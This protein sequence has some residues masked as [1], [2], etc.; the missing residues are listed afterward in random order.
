MSLCLP[1]RNTIEI[2]NVQVKHKFVRFKPMRACSGSRGKAPLFLTSAF[3][4]GEKST[5]RSGLITA[6]EE[7][8]AHRAEGIRTRRVTFLRHRHLLNHRKDLFKVDT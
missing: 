6:G 1:V 5:S 3:N 7:P 8:G 2:L 4:G